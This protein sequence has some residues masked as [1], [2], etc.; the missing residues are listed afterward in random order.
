MQLISRVQ[1]EL[2]L[3]NLKLTT[4]IL[5]M[6]E[7][8]SLWQLIASVLRTLVVEASSD[9]VRYDKSVDNDDTTGVTMCSWI[10]FVTLY[11]NVI[12]QHK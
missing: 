3:H 4:E 7:N 1:S 8:R 2:K 11:C 10:K 6:A 5:D 9:D 12:V